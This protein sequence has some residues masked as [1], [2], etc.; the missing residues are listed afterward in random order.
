VLITGRAR[1]IDDP[2]ELEQLMSLRLD[3][4]P[5]GHREAIIR[6]TTLEISG[7]TIHQDSST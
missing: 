3:P 1:R 2:S 6:I 5:G 4:W 7:R